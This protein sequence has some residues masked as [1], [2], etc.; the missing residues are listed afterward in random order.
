WFNNAAVDV[1]ESIMIGLVAA[2][3][4]KGNW[5][6]FQ[7]ADGYD[8]ER[9]PVSAP[10]PLMALNVDE[11]R[12]TSE[13]PP[14]ELPGVADLVSPPPPP[15]GLLESLSSS[16]PSSSS[17]SLST[18]LLPS[19]SSSSDST[20]SEVD[21]DE[22]DTVGDDDLFISIIFIFFLLSHRSFDRD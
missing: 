18:Q 22:G 3:N 15:P 1:A 20:R 7:E 17:S 11:G 9:F 8:A 19:F 2:A 4:I 14:Y 5:K 12:R 21:D 13:P 16:I 6:E 10:P